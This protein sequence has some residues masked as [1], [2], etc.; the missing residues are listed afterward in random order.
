[1]DKILEHQLKAYVMTVTRRAY[2]R[3]YG[4]GTSQRL[5]VGATYS[6]WWTSMDA[7]SSLDDHQDLRSW[8]EQDPEEEEATVALPGKKEL[9]QRRHSMPDLLPSKEIIDQDETL[10][11]IEL[12]FTKAFEA[13]KWVHNTRPC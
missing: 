2:A 7:T 3:G 8:S 11:P 1:M 4:D 13:Q 5:D 12:E 9:L 6:H 10:N